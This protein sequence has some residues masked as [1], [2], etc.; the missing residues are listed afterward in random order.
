ML[1]GLP[2]HVLNLC[3]QVNLNYG[4]DRPMKRMRDV[5]PWSKQFRILCH[6]SIQEQWRKKNLV[7]TQVRRLA[8][9]LSAVKIYTRV[10]KHSIIKY[11]MSLGR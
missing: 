4:D 11:K 9:C 7:I 1:W 2:S 10:A 8:G 3:D 5:I 6:R